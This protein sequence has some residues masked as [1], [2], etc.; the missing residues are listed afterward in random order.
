MSETRIVIS[1]E[2]D[3]VIRKA[4][5]TQLVAGCLAAM[6]LDGGVIARVVGVAML[7]FWLSVA[8]LVV[9]RPMKPSKVDLKF[10]HW[11]FWIVLVIASFRQGLT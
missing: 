8:F 2:Y 3:A 5:I 1:S 10:I 6:M 4:L 9:R 7:G 11:G